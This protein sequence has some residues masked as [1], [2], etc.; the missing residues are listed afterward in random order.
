MFTLNQKYDIDRNI[1]KSDH[2]LSSPSEIS[3]INIANSQIHI[4]I[5]GEDSVISLLKY[6]P[7]LKFNVLEAASTSRY[8]DAND[9]RLIILMMLMILTNDIS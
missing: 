4:N 8:V 5:H 3:K 2:I 7:N 9:T 1:L 6:Y